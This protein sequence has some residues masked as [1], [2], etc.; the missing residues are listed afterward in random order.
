[1][2]RIAWGLAGASALGGR[3]EVTSAPGRGTTITGRLPVAAA[4]PA[5]AAP[6]PRPAS[7]SLAR[8]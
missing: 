3:L 5:P 6:E 7:A 1:M 4:A 2:K 8:G